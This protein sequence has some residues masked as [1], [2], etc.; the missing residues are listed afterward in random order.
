MKKTL[1]AEEIKNKIEHYCAYQE[2]CVFEVKKKLM[3]LGA[4][5]KTSNE[6]I[7]WLTNEN[8]INEQR[9]TEAY[10]RSKINQKSWGK[11]KILMALKSFGIDETLITEAFSKLDIQFYQNQLLQL[12][13][14][15]NK[16]LKDE[17]VFIKKN[18][19]A[20]YLIGKGFEPQLVWE[21]INNIIND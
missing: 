3:Q 10:M 7:F 18:K 14:K 8:Y 20:Q 11:N 13:D 2:R 21:S 15:K 1:S 4:D 6:L 12:L 9:F 16:T 5:A 17:D 19:L